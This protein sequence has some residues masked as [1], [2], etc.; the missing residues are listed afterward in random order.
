[1]P[2]SFELD[3]AVVVH[4][5]EMAIQVLRTSD[6]SETGL[7]TYLANTI[8]EIALVAGFGPKYADQTPTETSTTR[9]NG[10]TEAGVPG[11]MAS[12]G[13]MTDIFPVDEQGLLNFDALFGNN[14]DL[15]YMLGLSADGN[16]EA[17][18]GTRWDGHDMTFDFSS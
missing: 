5:L 18:R 10:Q 12:G 1:M 6:L 11:D 13:P 14:G 9:D 17:D 7:S 3:R 16:A 15:G 2:S 4:Y 8:S